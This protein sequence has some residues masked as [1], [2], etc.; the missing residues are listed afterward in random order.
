[1]ECDAFP[2]WSMVPAGS[3]QGKELCRWCKTETISLKYSDNG[4]CEHSSSCG[5]M[6]IKHY[7]FNLG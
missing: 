7:L 2:R 4:A 6:L 5:E 1:M 3:R